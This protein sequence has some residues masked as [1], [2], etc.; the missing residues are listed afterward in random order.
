MTDGRSRCRTSTVGTRPAS[1]SSWPSS[2]SLKSRSPAWKTLSMK[3][4]VRGSNGALRRTIATSA[5]SGP[6]DDVA[7]GGCRLGGDAVEIEARPAGERQRAVVRHEHRRA[8]LQTI[9]GRAELGAAADSLGL[10]RIDVRIVEE[11]E[12]ELVAQQTANGLVDARLR[13]AAGAHELDEQLRQRL[14]AELVAAGGDDLLEPILGAQLL[15][16]PALGLED[17]A[18]RH[19][20]V[21]DEAPVGADH[22]VEAVAL[23]QQA[24]D[25]VAVEAEADLLVRRS[26]RAAVVRHDLRRSGREGGL[27]DAHVVLEPVAG[28]DLILPVGEMRDPRRRAAV[29][30]R[31]SAWSCT[32]RMRARAGRPGSRGCRRRRGVPASSAS[33]PKVCMIRAQ[34]GSVARSAIG[35]SATWIPTARYSRRA[36]SPNSRIA[37]SSRS[38]PKPIGSGQCENPPADQLAPRFSAKLWRGSDEIVTGMPSR[39]DSASRCIRFC[40]SACR[41]GSGA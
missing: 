39:V 19:R 7:V 30:R 34:R 9:A 5:S 13:D 37:S 29:R 12:P 25:H 40:H 14:A 1:S 22:A 32:R 33:S 3:L 27:E 15:D 20:S 4:S 26:D 41:R 24:R 6:L 18:V 17:R 11:P 35:C 8:P 38:A 16:A 21:G 10:V 2:G 28:I 23:A 36:M 31:G